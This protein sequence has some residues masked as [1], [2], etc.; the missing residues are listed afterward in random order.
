L[1]AAV[2]AVD[3]GLADDDPIARHADP[4]R[5]GAGLRAVAEEALQ[6]RRDAGGGGVVRGPR[7][8]QRVVLARDDRDVGRGDARGRP[9]RA[10]LVAVDEVGARDPLA[11]PVRETVARL[12]L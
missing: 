11:E 1:R 5:P 2:E 6:A 8:A 10:E 9:P 12:P 4:R 7:P 3:R